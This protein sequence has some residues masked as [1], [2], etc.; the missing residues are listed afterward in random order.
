M[1]SLA[2]FA[3]SV[4]GSPREGHKSHRKAAALKAQLVVAGAFHPA[5]LDSL[6]TEL[7]Q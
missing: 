3:S 7:Q 4:I 2:L 5:V 6:F 1:M